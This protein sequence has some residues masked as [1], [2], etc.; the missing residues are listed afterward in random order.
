ML[1]LQQTWH[2]FEHQVVECGVKLK[3]CELGCGPIKLEPHRNLNHEE[4]WWQMKTLISLYIHWPS[5]CWILI[6]QSGR[7][8]SAG[9]K[10]PRTVTD[11]VEEIH[12]VESLTM[13]FWPAC[14][15][16]LEDF[17]PSL[18]PLDWMTMWFLQRLFHLLHPVW[19]LLD[20]WRIKCKANILKGPL[21]Q[22]VLIAVRR[23]QWSV[24]H[25]WCDSVNIFTLF[26]S[27]YGASH[28]LTK[29][30]LH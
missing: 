15:Q 27:C 4:L 11:S 14:G 17:T 20:F 5:H 22:T 30:F 8:F 18:Q 23:P 26:W 7:K 21:I 6:G 19:P 2:K 9:L 16:C 28:C 13:L 10:L 1:S 25:L 29:E 12:S 24:Q 3:L